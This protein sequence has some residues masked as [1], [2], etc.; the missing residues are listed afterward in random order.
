MLLH[1]SG[2]WLKSLFH[3]ENVIVKNK[4]G[5]PISNSLQ[6]FGAGLTYARRYSLAAIVGLA[7]EDDDGKSFSKI[8]DRAETKEMA[9]SSANLTE[10]F[11]NM[12]KEAALDIKEFAQFA[13]VNSAKPATIESV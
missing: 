8:R 5:V 9:A 10:E 7:Q 13:G 1:E 11:M 3:I 6:Q 12:C 2:Q 4:E